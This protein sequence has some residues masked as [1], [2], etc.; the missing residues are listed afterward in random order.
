MRVWQKHI[1]DVS[2]RGEGRHP[3]TLVQEVHQLSHVLPV[4][5]A[6]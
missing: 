4:G 2:A 5:F 6:C 1:I 3:V